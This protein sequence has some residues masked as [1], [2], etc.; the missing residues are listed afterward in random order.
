MPQIPDVCEFEVAADQIAF[1]TI[2]NG[3]NIEIKNINMTQNAAASL[4]WLIN[5]DNHLTIEIK[6]KGD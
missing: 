1:Q 2:T 5:T 6:I 4:A 3:E